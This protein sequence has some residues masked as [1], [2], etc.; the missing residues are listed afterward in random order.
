LAAILAANLAAAYDLGAMS[1]LDRTHVLIECMRLAF[2]DAQRW[3]ADPRVVDI[4]VDALTSAAY[5]D[6][7]RRAISMESAAETVAYGSPGPGADTVYLS[8]VDGEGNACSF[9]NSL[10]MGTG[11]GLVVPGTGVSLQNRGALF[12]LDEG[13]PNALAA[14]KRPYQTIIPAMTLHSDGD[15]AGTLHACF[16]VMGGHMQPQGHLQVLVNIVDLGMSPQQALDLPRWQLT[17][18]SAGMGASEEGG[19]VMVEAGWGEETLRGLERRGHRL[20]RVDGFGRTAF[21]GGQVIL[22]NPSTGVLIGGSD[23]RKDGC[24]FGF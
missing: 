23:S 22:R 14:G 16:G 10:Y 8:V 19:V 18:A 6:L 5:A 24:A 4:P 11:S 20:R 12:E 7:C 15:N 13:H 1:E 21:G 9:I 2:A 17:A 3:V